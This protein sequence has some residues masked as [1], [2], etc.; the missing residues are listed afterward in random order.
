[1]PCAQRPGELEAPARRRLSDLCSPAAWKLHTAAT[2]PCTGTRQ[3]GPGPSLPAP[4]RQGRAGQ[5]PAYPLGALSVREENES[6]ITLA[7]SWAVLFR[8]ET[9]LLQ[10]WHTACQQ[11]LSLLTGERK[12]T[13]GAAPRGA[14]SRG[15]GASPSALQSAEVPNSAQM[16]FFNLKRLSKT[17]KE[18]LLKVML[19]KCT[20]V[21]VAAA[22]ECAGSTRTGH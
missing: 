8:L 15:D 3:W 2:H 17:K 4:R 9:D 14:S 22:V 1:M 6:C 18:M 13:R 16:S 11:F 10:G 12:E 20:N 21:S 19:E 7:T 5:V